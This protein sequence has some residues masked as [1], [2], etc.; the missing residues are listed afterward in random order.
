[1]CLSFWILFRFCV[2][3]KFYRKKKREHTD[4]LWW[5]ANERVHKSTLTCKMKSKKENFTR[6]THSLHDTEKALNE[7]EEGNEPNSF[8]VNAKHFS[9]CIHILY[10]LFIPRSLSFEPKQER[11][12][13]TH[14]P[15]KME[16]SKVRQTKAYTNDLVELFR[17]RLY[18]YIF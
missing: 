3:I 2:C 16:Q 14:T 18:A 6:K 11:Q 17:F 15:S 10:R 4:E 12:K 5:T 8:T 7:R 1:M 9:M 13:H